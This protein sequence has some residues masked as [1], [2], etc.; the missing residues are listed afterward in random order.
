MHEIFHRER[1]SNWNDTDNSFALNHE[2][3]IERVYHK[4]MHLNGPYP[5]TVKRRILRVIVVSLER[6]AL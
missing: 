6:T 5:N 1:Y 2:N 3:P 4:E